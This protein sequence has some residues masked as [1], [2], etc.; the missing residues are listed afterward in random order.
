MT[1]IKKADATKEA[2]RQALK[3]LMSE[4][5]FNQITVSDITGLCGFNRNTFYYHF[6]DIPSMVKDIAQ[7]AAEQ[8]IR[9]NAGSDSPEGL[10]DAVVKRMTANRRF[11]M[12]VYN[13]SDH[14]V[15]EKDL[16]ALC[17]RG[18]RQ[19]IHAAFD[20]TGLREDDIEILV[21]F[22]K[23]ESYGQF[24]DWLSSRLSFDISAQFH[25][26]CELRRGFAEEYIRRCRESYGTE[27]E[28]STFADRV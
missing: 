27:T 25:R 14:V 7:N 16:M 20:L 13:Y 24:L 26:L 19:Y 2:L 23:C 9:E 5:P 22:Y 15:F 17:E 4:K 28:A 10:V 1:S 18:T 3:T 6:Q 12:N 8:I 21:R 11:V